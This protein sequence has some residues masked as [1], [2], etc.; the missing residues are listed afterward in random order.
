M[1]IVFGTSRPEG[2]RGQC[3]EAFPRN[4]SVLKAFSKQLPNGPKRKKCSECDGQYCRIQRKSSEQGQSRVNASV[5]ENN[6]KSKAC[7]WHY[8]DD[9]QR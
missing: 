2:K 4:R 7:R 9:Q 6:T 5:K 1:E 8:Q 3:S